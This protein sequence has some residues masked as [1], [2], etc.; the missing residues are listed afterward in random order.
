MVGRARSGNVRESEFQFTGIHQTPT[1]G[2]GLNHAYWR[3]ANFLTFGSMNTPHIELVPV[4][5]LEPYAGNPMVHP[6]SQIRE[7]AAVISKF[8]F[9]Q[10]IIADINGV[11]I[12]GHGRLLAAKMLGMES[13]PVIYASD[14]T[15]DQIRA[16][17]IADNKIARKSSFDMELLSEEISKLVQAGFDTDLTGLNDDEIEAL[18]GSDFLPDTDFRVSE[19]TRQETPAAPA[20]APVSR[21]EAEQLRREPEQKSGELVEVKPPK[22]T[23]D[24]HSVFDCVM[25]HTDKVRLVKLLD[26]LRAQHGYEK[27]SEALMHMVRQFE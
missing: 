2:V 21:P 8:G 26:R 10:P 25:L 19:A 3:Y 27:A 4:S 20:P 7:L 11:I 17:R 16:F 1:A 22:A 13:V 6:D 9:K 18:L 15:E 23:D 12:A 24:Q 5:R 14:L